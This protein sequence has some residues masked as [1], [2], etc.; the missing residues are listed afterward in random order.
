MLIHRTSHSS[1]SFF[2]SSRPVEYLGE[3][4]EVDILVPRWAMHK[5]T[6]GEP[7]DAF[8]RRAA[9]PCGNSMFVSREKRRLAGLEAKAAKQRYA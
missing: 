6:G 4:W 7:S 3:D 1:F 2:H 9:S 8:E 5:L